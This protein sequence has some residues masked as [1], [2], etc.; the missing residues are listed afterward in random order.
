MKARTQAACDASAVEALLDAVFR[1]P[2]TFRM[3]YDHHVHRWTK[4]IGRIALREYAS[5]P[6]FRTAYHARGG[7]FGRGMAA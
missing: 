7:V 5:N 6:D 4:H 2:P 3:G 1:Q